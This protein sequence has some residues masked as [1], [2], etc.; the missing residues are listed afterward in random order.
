MYRAFLVAEL[1]LGPCKV[2]GV[3]R[4]LEF[5][6]GSGCTRHSGADKNISDL[7]AFL[8]LALVVCKACNRVMRHKP[9]SSILSKII[10]A[11]YFLFSVPFMFMRLGT[12]E[13]CLLHAPSEHCLLLV[14]V[15]LSFFWCPVCF[16]LLG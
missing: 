15:N 2:H 1:V 5:T 3:G 4:L 10:S 13:R 12:V 14:Y 6:Q 11:C 7:V 9:L 16:D 8:S